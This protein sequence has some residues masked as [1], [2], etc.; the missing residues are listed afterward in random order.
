MPYFRCAA[1]RIVL[2]VHLWFGAGCTPWC[3]VDVAV[4]VP[5]ASFDVEVEAM[6]AKI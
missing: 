3:S 6:S 5:L 2:S 1:Q 4:V